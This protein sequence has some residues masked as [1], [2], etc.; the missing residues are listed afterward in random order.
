MKREVLPGGILFITLSPGDL[1]SPQALYT[2]F[3]ELIVM[4]ELKRILVD[5]SQVEEATSLMIGALIALHL[6][7]YENLAVL[8]FTGLS[9][10]IKMLFGILG[11]EKV[12][13]SHYGRDEALDDFRPVGGPP[14]FEE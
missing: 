1:K 7:A 9:P 11:V 2:E 4:E 14:G 3:Q 10:K 12:M 13:E 5:L 8:K 6:L